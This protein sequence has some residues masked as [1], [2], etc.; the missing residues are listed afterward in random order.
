MER[1]DNT[2]PRSD[3]LPS[4]DRVRTSRGIA[5]P[6]RSRKATDKY[7]PGTT[8]LDDYTRISMLQMQLEPAP[9]AYENRSFYFFDSSSNITIAGR[10]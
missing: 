7:M 4:L 2:G 9:P 8:V 1:R 10:A 6:A 5:F 3:R